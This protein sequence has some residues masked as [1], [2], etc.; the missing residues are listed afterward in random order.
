MLDYYRED[1]DYMPVSI[2]EAWIRDGSLS[3]RVGARQAILSY[4]DIK[5]LYRELK[6]HV[7]H[8][9][10]RSATRWRTM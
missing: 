2:T 8:Y 7:E 5:E 4:P 10:L 6:A 9:G 3:I 1:F